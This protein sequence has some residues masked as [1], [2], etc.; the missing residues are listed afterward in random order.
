MALVSERVPS[1]Y[2]PIPTYKMRRG[3]VTPAQARALEQW[4][5]TLGVEVDGRRLDLPELFGRD[6]PVVLEIGCGMGEATV[7]MAAAEPERNLLAVDVHTPGLGRLLGAVASRGLTNVRVAEGDA[8]VLLAEMLQPASL[9]GVRVFFPDPWPKARHSKRRM[10]TPA[11]AELVASRL[12]PGGELH[13]ATDW[14][15]Y[16]EQVR[17]VLDQHPTFCFVQPPLRPRTRFEQ[18]ALVAGRPAHDVAVTRQ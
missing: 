10:V 2:P 6:A 16:A 15:P 13:V 12:V 5:P 4:W 11:F 1:P 18:R 17:Q 7:A 9:E 3:R 14:Q 8:L